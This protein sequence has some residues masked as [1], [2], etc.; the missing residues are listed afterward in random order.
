[1]RLFW[2]LILTFVG[3]EAL[4]LYVTHA[5]SSTSQISAPTAQ[6]IDQPVVSPAPPIQY[7]VRSLPQA[8]VHTL[9]IPAQSANRITPAVSE[10]VAS[11]KDFAGAY[12]ATAVINGGFF[13]PENQ[14]S[15]SH[16]TL[17]GQLVADARQNERLT[18]NPNLAPY[19]SK[20]F[21]RSEFRQYLCGP[22]VR[23][24]IVLHNDP[25]PADCKLVNAIGA[26]PRLLPDLNLQPE[27]FLEMA[28]GQVVRDPI[29]HDKLSPRSAI[30]LTSEGNVILVMAAQKPDAPDA[31]GLTLQQLADFMKSLGVEKALNLDGGGSSALYY[32]G[33]THYGKLDEQGNPIERPVKSVLVV[34]D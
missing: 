19:L 8:T 14:K 13:D 24:D 26:G 30:G 23:Y 2:I 29:D 32:Q 20:I 16:V 34:K 12:G 18:Q 7:A 25:T 31:S 27:S 11:L 5:P 33:K 17:E 1:M 4:L 28:N 10:G 15:T 6:S 9:V 22:A 3:L 21:N